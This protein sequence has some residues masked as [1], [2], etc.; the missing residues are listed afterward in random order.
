MS[1]R[2]DDAVREASLRAGF[3]VGGEGLAIDLVD[4]IKLAVDPVRDLLEPPGRYSAFWAAHAPQLPPR[5]GMMLPD[6]PST[7]RLRSAA[8]AVFTAV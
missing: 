7:L 3:T 4:T 8:R 5:S 2:R 1:P 6:I